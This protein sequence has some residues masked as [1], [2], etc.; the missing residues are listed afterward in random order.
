MTPLMRKNYR[1]PNFSETQGSPCENFWYCETKDIWRKNVILRPQSCAKAFRF[2]NVSDHRSVPLWIAL[3]LWDKK[4]QTENHDTAPSYT[5]YFLILELF[6]NT[7]GS[8]WKAFRYFETRR[9]SN[10][11]VIPFPL[12]ISINLFDT[13]GF[14]ANRRLTLWK[15]FVPWNKNYSTETRGT[16]SHAKKT[17][18]ITSLPASLLSCCVKKFET[19]F[20]CGTQKCS[21]T[22]NFGT[23]RQKILDGSSW[24]YPQPLVCKNN[25]KT[26]SFLNT[27]V[28]L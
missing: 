19:R 3:E 9:I 14:L 12:L 25:F 7:E 26:R 13:R 28:L 1:S 2:Q 21:F 15:S 27:N 20:F 10:K 6:W 4:I 18:V 17:I 23:V 24:Y 5:K 8:L 22:K 16:L 11:I